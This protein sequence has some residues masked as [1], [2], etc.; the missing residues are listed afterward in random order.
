[1]VEMTF[2]KNYSYTFE[3]TIFFVD[4]NDRITDARLLLNYLKQEV[5]KYYDDA[6][7]S[8]ITYLLLEYFFNIHKQ[9]V[10]IKKPVDLNKDDMGKLAATL[11]RI[12]NMEPIQYIIGTADFYGRKYVVNPAVL[13][14]RPETEELVD[15]VLRENPETDLKVLDIGTGSG[16]IAISLQSHLKSAEVYGLDISAQ[17]LKVAE[18]NALLNNVSI[19]WLEKDILKDALDLQELDLIVSN[20]PYV[21]KKESKLMSK[22]VLKYEPQIALFVPDKDPLVF[23]KKII[24]Q[25]QK[26]LRSKGKLYFEINEAYGQEL[27]LYME[28]NGFLGVDIFED[29]QG[30]ERMV[31]GHLGNA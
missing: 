21:R 8:S 30:K 23:Y 15:L 22:N 4:M 26:M 29:F 5:S 27:K 16:C 6:E 19:R 3:T 25:A 17:A 13:I 18:E 14:P 11:K 2:E 31:R 12:K 1:M 9:D 7:A 28:E 10:I 20:P 24:H